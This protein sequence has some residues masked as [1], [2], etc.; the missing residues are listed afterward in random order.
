MRTNSNSGAIA[1]K[2]IAGAPPLYTRMSAAAAR[3]A[4]AN[5]AAKTS[6]M[7]CI[8]ACMDSP[9]RGGLRKTANLCRSRRR[10][11]PSTA[12]LQFGFPGTPYPASAIDTPCSEPWAPE[13]QTRGRQPGGLG[14][15]KK[16]LLIIYSPAG[17]LVIGAVKVAVQPVLS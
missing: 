3:S 10:A 12:K 15:Q 6:A 16:R 7:S 11:K 5:T 17:R 1:R 2:A 8:L 4:I 14:K 9:C 13:A